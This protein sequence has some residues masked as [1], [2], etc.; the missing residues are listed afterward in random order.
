M[1]GKQAVLEP[2]RFIRYAERRLHPTSNS[3]FPWG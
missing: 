2:F 3:R 1:V